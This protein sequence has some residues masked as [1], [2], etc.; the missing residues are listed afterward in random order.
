MP[1]ISDT[2][3][4]IKILKKHF[5]G[6][7]ALIFQNPLELLIATILSAECTDKR[8]NLVTKELFK[9]YKKAQNYANADLKTL[10]TEIRSTGF[11]HNKA[12]N[13]KMAARKIHKE[14]KDKIPSKMEDLL[15]LPGVARKT[16]NVVLWNAFQKNVGIAVDTHVKRISFRLGLTKNTDPE[17]IEKD[18]MPII[19]RKDWGIFTHLIG[20]HGRTFCM[21][22]KP[23]CKE[24]PLCKLCPSCGKLS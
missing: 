15:K 5:S 20:D 11:Y 3:Q 19:Q 16:A 18:L 21:A 6:K 1:S 7:P 10:E 8:V 24:C 12:K 14:F 17:K 2:T 22:K 13:I 4:I 9:K 23:K